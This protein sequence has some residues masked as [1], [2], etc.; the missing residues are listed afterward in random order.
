MRDYIDIFK[1]LW[2]NEKGKALI[3]LFLYLIFLIIVIVY[4][5]TTKVN[6][7]NNT[8]INA[9]DSFKNMTNYTEVVTIDNN[10]YDLDVSEYTYLKINNMSYQ[11]L[12]NSVIS[13][14]D[15]SLL[16]FDIYF[17]NITPKS[18]YRLI[19]DKD[20]YSNTSYSD[21]LKSKTYLVKLVDFLKEVNTSLDIEMIEEI[22]DIDIKITMSEKSKKIV[23]VE[24]ELA[25]YYKIRTG[26][27]KE[28]DIKIEY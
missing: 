19:K 18:I 13:S 11:I 17:W 21:G 5:R 4:I 8:A 2:G 22:K 26:I 20:I 24:L 3:K 16:N 6:R 1:T 25:D 10:K 14:I 15:N 27:S 12:N 7:H 28:Y 9:I 23:S